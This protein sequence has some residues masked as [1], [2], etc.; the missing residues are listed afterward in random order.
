M[1]RSL[2]TAEDDLMND[3]M[4]DKKRELV[5]QLDWAVTSIRDRITR[6]T[7]KTP[8]ALIYKHALEAYHNITKFLFI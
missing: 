5:S 1:L 2:A 7:T 8:E 3:T 6:L 4:D